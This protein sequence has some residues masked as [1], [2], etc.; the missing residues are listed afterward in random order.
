M[1]SSQ[2][3][4][5]VTHVPGKRTVTLLRRKDMLNYVVRLV[6]DYVARDVVEG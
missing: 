4:Q 2:K 3:A 5:C 1:L 6:A